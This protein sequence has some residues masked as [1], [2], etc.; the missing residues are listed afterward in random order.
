MMVRLHMPL[1]PW[2]VRIFLTLI[3]FG[4]IDGWEEMEV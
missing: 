1:S 2:S 4:P 3:S